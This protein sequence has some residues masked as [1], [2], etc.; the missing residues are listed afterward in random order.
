MPTPV[1]Q[2]TIEVFVRFL[3]TDKGNPVRNEIDS[4]LSN[5]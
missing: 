4:Q 5:L 3:M 1:G 2:D